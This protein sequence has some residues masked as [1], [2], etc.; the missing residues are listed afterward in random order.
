MKPKTNWIL[1]FFKQQKI[2]STIYHHL[3]QLLYPFVVFTFQ[4]LNTC[5]IYMYIRFTNNAHVSLKYLDDPGKFFMQNKQQKKI[6]LDF[7]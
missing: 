7:L 6:L 5:S 4:L 2:H 1:C 3:C